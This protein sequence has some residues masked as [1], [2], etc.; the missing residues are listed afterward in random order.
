MFPNFNATLETR[1]SKKGR[2]YLC[3]S[4]KLTDNVEKIVFLEPTE[5]ELLKL[6]YNLSDNFEYSKNNDFPDLN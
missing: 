6:K 4:I 1:I 3:L 5:V 2:P